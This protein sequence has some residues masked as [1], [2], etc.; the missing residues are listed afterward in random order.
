MAADAS[1]DELGFYP[2]AE[3]VFGIVSAIG[4]EYRPVIDS[5]KNYLRQFGY[6]SI[7]I[8]I[9]DLFETFAAELKLEIGS[10]ADPESKDLMW[11]KIEIGDKIC[12][13]EAVIVLWDLGYGEPDGLCQLRLAGDCREDDF[14]GTSSRR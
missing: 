1:D 13:F 5:L 9:S 10:S 3:L 4:V 14:P 11:R 12:T 8:K 7:E 6:T 2:E